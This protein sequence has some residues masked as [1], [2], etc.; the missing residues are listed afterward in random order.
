M[1]LPITLTDW[2]ALDLL[3][4]K[5][6]TPAVIGLSLIEGWA[7]SRRGGFDWR[8]LGVSALD[9]MIRL[10]LSIFVAWSLFKPLVEWS[11]AHRFFTLD[12]D[13]WTMVGLLFI[14]QEFCYYWYHRAA[15]RVR[16]FWANHVVHHSPNDLNLGAAYRI[17]LMGKIAGTT[18]FFI[19]M[20][21]LGFHPKAVFA[22]LTLNLLYQFWLHTTW[23]PKLGL[24]EW[25]FNTPSAHRV[26]HAGNIEYLDA[27]Y[28]GVLI[29]FD[30]LFGTY[31]AE[32]ADLP[33]RYGLVKPLQGHNL[34]RIEFHEW[35]ALLADLRQ[36]RSLRAVLGALF[37]PPGWR[38]DGKGLTTD[39]L[40]RQH[41][42]MPHLDGAQAQKRPA[43]DAGPDS[44]I[45][46]TGTT[47]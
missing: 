24:L 40:R 44:G 10:A 37:A 41:G 3:L 34:L 35:R 30:R 46:T 47:A 19:P 18:P 12:I 28:G 31:K 36:A 9:Q 14:S 13:S 45:Q 33:C 16:W 29:L 26:H 25:V 15:H 5:Y 42:L 39:E 11:Y 2:K 8:A 27:N 1:L 21:L 32:R 20:T 6:A 4:L 7:L 22:T 38:P 43:Q 23:I 17:G